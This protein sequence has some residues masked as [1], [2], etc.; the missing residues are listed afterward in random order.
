MFVTNLLMLANIIILRI[1]V[2]REISCRR[3]AICCFVAFR[4]YLLCCISPELVVEYS[5]CI[6]TMWS[7][8]TSCIFR[9]FRRNWGWE[10]RCWS[11]C[12]PG[13]SIAPPIPWVR[14]IADTSDVR[15]YKLSHLVKLNQTT[16][17]CCRTL[18]H[19]FDTYSKPTSI[20]YTLTPLDTPTHRSLQH[21]FC[22][23]L[24]TQQGLIIC[25]I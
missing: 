10:V 15:S 23:A 16:P 4:L 3:G 8:Y 9:Q 21:L 25:C 5:N 12:L 18:V 17:H 14:F 2:T 20:V 13:R 24:P 7:D 11:S 1:I 19:C 6:P 22:I